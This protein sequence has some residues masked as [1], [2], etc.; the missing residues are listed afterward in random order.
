MMGDGA[1]ELDVHLL[2]GHIKT[3]S[4]DVLNLLYLKFI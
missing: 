4:L 3:P 2:C 1:V